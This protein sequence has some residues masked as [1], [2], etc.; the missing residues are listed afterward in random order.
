MTANY[1]QSLYSRNLSAATRA[2]LDRVNAEFDALV[3]VDSDDGEWGSQTTLR[4]KI[5]WLE[6][7]KQQHG[8]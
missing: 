1:D 3:P 2:E 7:W 4:A 8:K 6:A 5:N